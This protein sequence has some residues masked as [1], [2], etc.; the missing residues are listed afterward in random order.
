MSNILSDN[1]ILSATFTSRKVNMSYQCHNDYKLIYITQGQVDITCNQSNYLAKKN[2]VVLI[3]NLEKH[4]FVPRTEKY[5]RYVVSLQPSLLEP[6]ISNSILRNLLKNHPDGFQHCIDVSPVKD[7]V[8]E[9]FRKLCHHKANTPFA[10]Q[11][12]ACYV[13]ELLILLLEINPNI[14]PVETS[15]CKDVVLQVQD[16]IDSH[17]MQNISVTEIGKQYGISPCYLSHSFK[18]IIGH[19]PKQYITLL[20]LRQ[21]GYLLW[22]SN[23]SVQKVALECGFR[24]INNYTKVFKSFYGCTPGQ[25][26]KKR[27]WE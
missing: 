19:S 10:N 25:Y 16:Y 14:M 8:L 11:K 4:Q 9:L 3:S 7:E 23:L 24:D 13:T 5:E 2:H 17:F 6:Y 18:T 1:L 26:R 21:S 22:N 20:R 15:V 12:A 27:F